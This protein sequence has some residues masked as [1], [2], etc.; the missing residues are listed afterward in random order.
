[1]KV[2]VDFI[3]SRLARRILVLFF[4]CALLP[5]ATVAVLAFREVGQQFDLQTERRL[6]Q[7]SKSLGMY[8]YQKLLFLESELLAVGGSDGSVAERSAAVTM[9][10]TRPSA[11]DSPDAAW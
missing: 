3:R 2:E 11:A 4:F 8:V 5:S 1:M 6:H 7:S 10:G 9:S